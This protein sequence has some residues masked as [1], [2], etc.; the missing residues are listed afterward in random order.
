MTRDGAREQG[1]RDAPAAPGLPVK[2]S[3]A[4]NRAR[5]LGA[6]LI[7]LPDDLDQ[8]A[9]APHFLGQ[10]LDLGQDLFQPVRLGIGAGRRRL[11]G[12]NGPCPEL[13]L[14]DSWTVHCSAS[15]GD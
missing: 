7:E 15:L 6:P 11:R 1:G 9:V 13:V 4:G 5:S 8:L 2:R 14:S 3:N 10:V 12:R